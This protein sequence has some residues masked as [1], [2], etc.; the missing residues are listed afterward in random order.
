[1][2]LRSDGI[3]PGTNHVLILARLGG[4]LREIFGDGLA[5]D[6][7]RVAVQQR[8]A[9]AGSS[10]LAECRPRA[11]SSVATYSPEGF[12]SQKTGTRRPN[13]LEIVERE[14]NFGGVGDGHQVQDGVGRA[15]DGH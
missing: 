3:A 8:R 1:M 7:Q 14:R 9:R 15:A 4:N 10:L 2:A 5:G 11:C 6:G 13:G 12:R